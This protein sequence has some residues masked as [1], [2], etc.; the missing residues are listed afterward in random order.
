MPIDTVRTGGGGEFSLTVH[1][2]NRFVSLVEP[3][4]YQTSPWYFAINPET[5]KYNFVLTRR[6][7]PE[8]FSFI[9]FT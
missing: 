2:A 7:V 5:A 8:K 9:Q 6:E 1:P 3:A 4:D